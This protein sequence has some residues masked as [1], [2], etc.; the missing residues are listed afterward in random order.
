MTFEKKT[1]R[2]GALAIYPGGEGKRTV[3]QF[4]RKQVEE[5]VARGESLAGI[6][7]YRGKLHRANLAGAILT[8]AKLRRANLIEADLCGTDLREADLTNADLYMANLEGAD[9]RGVDF[10]KANLYKANLRGAIMPDGSKHE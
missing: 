1:Q 4:S 7:L 8:G 5:M 10:S 3:A 9:L 6:N 2:W